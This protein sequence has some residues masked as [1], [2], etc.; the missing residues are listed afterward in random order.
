MKYQC[1]RSLCPQVADGN[2]AD[3]AVGPRPD[4]EAPWLERLYSVF[5]TASSIL[6]DFAVHRVGRA[7]ESEK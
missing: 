2:V 6:I 5:V 4:G 1:F 7:A 3:A